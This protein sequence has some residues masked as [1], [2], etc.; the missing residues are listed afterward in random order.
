MQRLRLAFFQQRH[1]DKVEWNCE[2]F[3]NWVTGEKPESP[4]VNGWA[5]LILIVLA[6]RMAI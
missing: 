4:Q 2:I 5:I 6:V 3:A 1:Y